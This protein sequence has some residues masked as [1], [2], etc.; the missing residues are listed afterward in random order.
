M[1]KEKTAFERIQIK[2]WYSYLNKLAWNEAVEFHNNEIRQLE[3]LKLKGRKG[4]SDKFRSQR[5]QLETLQKNQMVKDPDLQRFILKAEEKYKKGLLR[6]C[7]SRKE[8]KHYRT[9]ERSPRLFSLKPINNL[10]PKSA[11]KF[12]DGPYEIFDVFK[13]LNFRNALNALLNSIE[14]ISEPS[15]KSIITHLNNIKNSG[16]SSDKWINSLAQEISNYIDHGNPN[17]RLGAKAWMKLGLAFIQSRFL[18]D[19]HALASCCFESKML[20]T[21]EQ[22][23]GIPQAMWFEKVTPDTESII[24]EFILALAYAKKDKELSEAYGFDFDLVMG[25]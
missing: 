15:D 13:A 11:S 16:L 9:A 24:E 10:F 8:L 7:Y 22:E 19:S 25:L 17:V 18:D 5:Q 4:L 2:N 14:R 3:G 1:A 6:E 21:I 12:T 20:I 23:Y